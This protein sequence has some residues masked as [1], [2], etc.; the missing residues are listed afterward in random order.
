MQILRT[1]FAAARLSRHAIVARVPECPHSALQ[2]H[3]I[4]AR[5][6]ST[7]SASSSS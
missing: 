3:R 6:A 1:S 2:D 4:E 5:R 7:T